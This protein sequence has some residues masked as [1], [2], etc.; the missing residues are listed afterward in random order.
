MPVFDEVILSTQAMSQIINLDQVDQQVALDHHTG[1]VTGGNCNCG[2]SLEALPLW[3]EAPP[4]ALGHRP[5]SLPAP[6]QTNGA[7][8]AQAGCVLQAL[9]D[10]V[11]PH[12]FMMPL[13]N[14]GGRFVPSVAERM[15]F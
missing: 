8:V 9:D 4:L 2:M 14:R 10:H 5:S 11:A 15:G 7:L 1:D 6:P 3:M 12:G 13:V